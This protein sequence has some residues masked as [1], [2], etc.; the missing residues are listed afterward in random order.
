MSDI[1]YVTV[2]VRGGVDGRRSPSTPCKGRFYIHYN[3]NE[4][5]KRRYIESFAHTV[6][7]PARNLTITRVFDDGIE[8]NWI[9]PREPN[10]D[11]QHYMIKCTT[12]N[13]SQLKIRT[14]NNTNYHNLTGL[15]VGQTYNN[16]SVVALNSAGGGKGSQP[17]NHYEHNSTVKGA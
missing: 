9:Q 6:P 15:E 3:I 5:T 10:G 1:G 4:I 7:S 17:I 16:I 14:P 12:Q 8:L 13:G 11:I 2:H